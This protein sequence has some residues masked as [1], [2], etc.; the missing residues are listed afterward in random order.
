MLIVI[1]IFVFIFLFIIFDCNERIE[2]CRRPDY[3]ER[4]SE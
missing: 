1:I 3:R 2:K 4:E